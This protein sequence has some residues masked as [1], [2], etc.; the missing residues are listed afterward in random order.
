[1]LDPTGEFLVQN[2][3]QGN[4]RFYGAEAEAVFTLKPDEIDLR[5]FTDYVR[6]KLD[7]GGNVPRATPLRFGLEFN[8]R[9]GPWTANISA[10][11]VVRQSRLAEL[12]TG[13]P[14]YTLVN[15]EVSYRIK[16]TRSNGIRLFLQ[17]KN[18][19]DEEMRVHTSFLKNFAPLP[20]RAIVAGLRGEF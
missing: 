20:G 6:G 7:V 8:H 12:E 9:T 5:V 16:E 19:L 14:G 2:F 10:T 13:T 15:A 3:A 18:L 17:G 11:R 1:M 4:A